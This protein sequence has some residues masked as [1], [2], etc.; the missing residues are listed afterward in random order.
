MRVMRTIVATT[1]LFFPA[2]L[3]AADPFLGK[4]TLDVQRSK[5]PTG[6]RPKQMTI[7]MSA[8]G[9]GVHYHS[10][11]LLTNGRSVSADYAAEYDGKPVVVLGARGMLLPVSLKRTAP[12][13]V[14]ATYT[15]GFQVAAISRRVVSASGTIMMVTTTSRDASGKPVTNVGVYRKVHP[16]DGSFELSKARTDL[17]VPK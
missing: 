11:T 6:T 1:I 17:L 12:K 10:E 2:L 5:Y 4:W 14:V 9:H 13:I 15:S 8:A 3:W 16:P 7:E